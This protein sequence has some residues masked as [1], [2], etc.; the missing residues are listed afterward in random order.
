MI[1]A[2][3]T[4]TFELDREAFESLKRAFKIG[5]TRPIFELSFRGR[6]RMLVHLD[7]GADLDAGELLATSPRCSFGAL[8]GPFQR[9]VRGQLACGGAPLRGKP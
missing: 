9:F 1:T 8:C 3:G 6:C 5:R 2:Q 4:Y 7:E